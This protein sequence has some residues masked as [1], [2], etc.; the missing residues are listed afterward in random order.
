MSLF[1]GLSVTQMLSDMISVALSLSRGSMK[2]YFLPLPSH[3]FQLIRP[4]ASPTTVRSWC[5]C[6]GTLKGVSDSGTSRKAAD[7]NFV[8]PSNNT[9]HCSNPAPHVMMKIS[10]FKNTCKGLSILMPRLQDFCG[11]ICISVNTYSKLY[12]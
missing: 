4:T 10:I 2:S 5:R 7:G 6:Y 9:A 12:K 1:G 11:F 3:S 8:F